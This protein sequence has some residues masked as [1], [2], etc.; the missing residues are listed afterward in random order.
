VFTFHTARNTG[1]TF[2]FAVFA[3]P[4]LDRLVANYDTDVWDNTINN[5]NDDD[6]D[7]A[8]SLGDFCMI[9]GFQGQ[10][11]ASTFSE[12][13][14]INLETREWIKGLA[15]ETP[16]FL[17]LGNHEQEAGY[18]PQRVQDHDSISVWGTSCRLNQ[19][20]NPQD[21]DNFYDGDATESVCCGKRENYW[22]FEWGD[23]IFIGLDPYWYTTTNPFIDSGDPWDWTLGEDQHDWL[24]ETLDGTSATWKFIFIHQI[25]GGSDNGYGRGGVEW[26]KYSVASNPSYEWGGE[27]SDGNDVWSTKRSGWTHDPIHDIL[28][29]ANVN[30]VFFG[31]DHTYVYNTLD[32]VVYQHVGQPGDA[33]YGAGMAAEG[34]GYTDENNVFKNN[35]GH[36]LVTVYGSDSVHVE[37]KRSVLEADAPLSENGD[38]V[39]N[40]TIS[41]WYTLTP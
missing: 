21:D 6:P 38:T 41:H 8:V 34:V 33:T 29:N 36:V 19:W 17:V 9:D 22:S 18:G 3:D 1:E 25:V 4:H 39:N 10:G 5:I 31:H 12:V 2:K 7:F 35:S 27:D 30:I 11:T 28:D 16:L 32:G 40:K 15:V 26:A 24:Y 37:W 13:R 14:D 23:A 20:I